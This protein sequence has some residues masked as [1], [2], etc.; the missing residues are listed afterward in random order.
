MSNASLSR[1]IY[2]MLYM[3]FLGS[4]S[5]VYLKS[6]S[7]QSVEMLQGLSISHN[8]HVKVGLSLGA[9]DCWIGDPSGTFEV[10]YLCATWPVPTIFEVSSLL[11]FK[12]L[13][14]VYKYEK[15]TCEKAGFRFG[16]G[17]SLAEQCTSGFLEQS[18]AHSKRRALS[19]LNS[20]L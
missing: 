15:K 11:R 19:F 5:A 17:L 9:S 6:N 4:F 1:R 13:P 14:K 20:V 7:E 2:N 10:S 3:F 12:M 8:S 16:Q 18:I